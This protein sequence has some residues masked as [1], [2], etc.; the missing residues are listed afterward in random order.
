MWTIRALKYVMLPVLA[1]Y[2]LTLG[3]G[4]VNLIV[5]GAPLAALG[6]SL[7][8]L[9]GWGGQISLGQWAFAGFG[10]AIGLSMVQAGWNVFIACL[11][12]GLVGAGVSVLIG[13]PALRIKGLF[14]AV[15]TFS[16]ALTA[17]LYFL[18]RQEF[19]YVP[20]SRVIRPTVWGKF[21]LES[22]YVFLYLSLAWLVFVLTSLRSIRNSR[23]GRVLLATRENDRGAQAFGVRVILVRSSPHSP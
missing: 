6:L 13:I 11:V 3:P 9:T 17:N 19:G 5:Y 8:L 15:A 23:T 16:F 22:E 12:A 7:V 14:L 1:L 2:P 10:A 21:D 18:N 20:T 4:R